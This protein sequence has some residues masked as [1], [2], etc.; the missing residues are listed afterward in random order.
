MAPGSAKPAARKRNRKRKRRNVSSSSS[1]SSSSDS[2][3]SSGGISEHTP[4]TTAKLRVHGRTVV[5][6][7][8]AGEDTGD[9]DSSE[10]ESSSNSKS[11]AE[12]SDV[13]MAPVAQPAAANNLA[14]TTS[15]EASTA[16][17]KTVKMRQRY[18]SP[19]PVKDVPPP[20]MLPTNNEQKEQAL[21]DRFRKFWMSN[22]ADAFADD[23]NT[24]RNVCYSSILC[25]CYSTT[26]SL[27]F[28][29]EPNLTQSR[30]TLLI[31]S[32]ASGAEVYS[33]S[34]GPDAKRTNEMEVI[35]G[36]S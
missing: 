14:P 9:D 3:S 24:I 8:S 30:L 28:K 21:K 18:E 33:S 20:T 17:A 22:I 27:Y 31:D 15:A 32:L 1:S 11:S 23:L 35:L 2:E 6:V 7:V 16:P 19:P 34:S 26:D 36:D 12:D 13:E 4:A 25:Y 5:K 10:S 29:K